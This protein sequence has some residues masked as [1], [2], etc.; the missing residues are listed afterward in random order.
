MVKASGVHT[1]YTYDAEN[2]LVKVE[3]FAAG[4]TTPSATSSYRYDGLGRR[5]EKVGN[6]LTRRYI[7][8]GEDILLEYDETNTLLAHYTHGPGIDEP[9]AMTRGTATYYYHQDGLGSVTDLTDSTASTVKTYSYDAWGNIVQQT[10][11]VENPYTYTGREVDAETGLYYYRARYYDPVI[12]RFLQKDPILFLGGD[13]NL[14]PYVSNNPQLY[15]DALGLR[16]RKP[17]HPKFSD[18]NLPEGYGARVDS[19]NVNGES[20]F[21]IHV[22]DGTGKEIGVYGPEGWIN[23]HGKGIPT[24]VPKGVEN[25]LKGIAI[26]ELRARGKFPLKGRA[27]IRGNKWLKQVAKSCKQCG[28]A[29]VAIGVGSALADGGSAAEVTEAAAEPF[30]CPLGCDEAY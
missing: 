3:E 4:A 8:D 9:V 24:A 25:G 27:N 7:Y 1:D 23:K 11:T 15:T 21:E 13:L 6:G 10:G 12:G 29:G 16:A 22:C 14:Y 17:K 28:L 26:N 18:Y 5:I 2:R 20:S 19:F 30:I